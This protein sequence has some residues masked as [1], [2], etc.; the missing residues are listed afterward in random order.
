MKVRVHGLTALVLVGLVAGC[1]VGGD[2]APEAPHDPGVP[3]GDAVSLACTSADAE[4]GERIPMGDLIQLDMEL[5]YEASHEME[6]VFPDVRHT[7]SGRSRVEGTSSQLACMSEQYGYTQFELRPYAEDEVGPFPVVSRGEAM[8][9]ATRT[10]EVEGTTMREDV[11]FKG[12]LERL[13]VASVTVRD[14]TNANGACVGIR[15]IA[16]LSGTSRSSGRLNGKHL[17][18]DSGPDIVGDAYSALAIKTYGTDDHEFGTRGLS[19]CMGDPHAEPGVSG[20]PPQG[21]KVSAD[22]RVW[23]RDGEWTGHL[24]GPNE[25]RRVYF[26]MRVVPRTLDFTH[27]QQDS[28]R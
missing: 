13:E 10:I 26:R 5:R 3:S 12:P 23:S 27:P 25:T 17:E 1:D 20:A 7:F 9:Q 16:P 21:M 18:Q 15:F 8:V 28:P 2:A 4:T 22:S 19:I 11:D 24:S 6:S 14:D